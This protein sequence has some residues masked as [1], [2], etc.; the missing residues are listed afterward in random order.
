MSSP[1]WWEAETNIERERN[2]E[3]ERK[4][5]RGENHAYRIDEDGE[6][7]FMRVTDRQVKRG[8]MV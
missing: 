6:I 3:R 4:R 8:E 7:E 5:E 2:R 1:V